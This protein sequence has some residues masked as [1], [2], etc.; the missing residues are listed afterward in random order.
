MRPPS[1]SFFDAWVDFLGADQCPNHHVI[2]AAGGLRHSG[3]PTERRVF[4]TLR[5]IAPVFGLLCGL[6]FCLS[7]ANAAEVT[8]IYLYP[9]A[10]P[11]QPYHL[12]CVI[13][14]SSDAP[15]VNDVSAYYPTIDVS[16]GIRTLRYTQ[17][18][19]YGRVITRR[20][21]SEQCAIQ[22]D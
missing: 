20:L 4:V 18:A 19:L 14:G 2:A 11:N 10:K 13:P 16:H 12:L 9:L 22:T 15:V 17:G 3:G 5:N 6:W 7:D 8:H 1:V 21:T